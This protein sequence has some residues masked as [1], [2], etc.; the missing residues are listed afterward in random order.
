[1]EGTTY[2]MRKA[3]GP[4]ALNKGLQANAVMVL[5][6]VFSEKT[7]AVMRLLYFNGTS[8]AAM[9]LDTGPTPHLEEVMN[10]VSLVV[11][12]YLPERVSK[13]S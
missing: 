12:E 6:T 8:S 3:K 2:K 5:I 11:K 10:S 7:T 1:M 4:T 13:H 9:N